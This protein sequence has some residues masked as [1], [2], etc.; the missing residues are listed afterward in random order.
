MLDEMMKEMKCLTCVHAP[1]CAIQKGGVNLQLVD[2]MGCD[3]Y[4]Q[5]TSEGSVAISKEEYERFQQIENTLKRISTVSPTEAEL[6]NK[7]LKETIAIVLAQK[8]NIWK[9]YNEKCKEL[10]QAHNRAVK[11]YMTKLENR[12]DEVDIIL[13]EDS[14]EEYLYINGL[15]DL[16][17]E[18]AKEFEVEINE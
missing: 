16:M 9:H 2:S 4:Q 13:H 17:D 5:K 1:V 6:E 3:Y 15:L 14:D 10:E 7:A 18:I 12:L 11:D 8:R